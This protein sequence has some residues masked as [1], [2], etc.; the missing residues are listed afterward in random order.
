MARRASN[1]PT[2]HLH[3]MVATWSVSRGGEDAAPGEITSGGL[4]YTELCK[5]HDVGR[6]WT[7]TKKKLPRVDKM[8]YREPTFGATCKSCYVQKSVS[9]DC[10]C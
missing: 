6:D 8:A 5:L 4:T 10:M 2:P 9:G 7:D 3:D 1:P